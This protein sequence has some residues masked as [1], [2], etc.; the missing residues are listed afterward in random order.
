MARGP[1]SQSLGEVIDD[2]GVVVAD[3]DDSYTTG[4]TW[5]GIALFI[6]GVAAL[7][8]LAAYVLVCRKMQA[9]SNSEIFDSMVRPGQ[10]VA[11]VT[12]LRPTIFKWNNGAARDV[13]LSY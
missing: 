1:N 7:L 8:S 9:R 11:T 12:R 3:D 4:T 6:V 2:G 13:N 10:L 5:L